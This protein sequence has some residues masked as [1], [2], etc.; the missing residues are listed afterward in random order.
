MVDDRLLYT[1]AEM[2]QRLA[3]G[4]TRAYELVSSGTVPVVRVGRS[5]R[6]PAAA[7]ARWVDERSA[8][9]VAVTHDGR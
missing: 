3:I 6:V 7:L 5:I 8:T 4:R 2:A 9:G 1:V